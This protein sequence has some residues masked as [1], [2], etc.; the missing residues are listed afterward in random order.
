[1]NEYL[2]SGRHGAGILDNPWVP[3]YK[4]EDARDRREGK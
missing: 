3:S 2:D 1:M 4:E